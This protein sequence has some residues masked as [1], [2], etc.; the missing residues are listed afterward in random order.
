M[1][2]GLLQETA[3]GG[4]SVYPRAQ[5]AAR[6]HASCARRCSTHASVRLPVCW[7]VLYTLQAFGF[8]RRNCRILVVGLDNSGK[9]TLI[10][11]LK[12]TKVRAARCCI[13]PAAHARLAREDGMGR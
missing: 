7:T 6:R 10:N 13:I 12:P 9:S 4:C 2:H 11:F 1:Q 3:A 8:T 5:L